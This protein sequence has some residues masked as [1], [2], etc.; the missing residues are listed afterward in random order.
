[1]QQMQRRHTSNHIVHI[2]MLL[3]LMIMLLLTMMLLMPTTMAATWPEGGPMQQM[4]PYCAHLDVDVVDDNAVVDHDGVDAVKTHAA[5]AAFMF[6]L[7]FFGNNNIVYKPKI[8]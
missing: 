1:M 8:T 6:F 4:Q 5:D 7:Q 3:L 2:F